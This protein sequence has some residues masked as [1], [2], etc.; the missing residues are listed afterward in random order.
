MNAVQLNTNI[1][2][3]QLDGNDLYFDP[4]TLYAPFGLLPW[5]EAGVKGLVLSRAGATWVAIPNPPAVD[6]RLEHKG[7]LQL[8]EDGTLSGHVTV[9]YSGLEALS[10]RI[11]ERHDDAA[12]R[13]RYLENELQADIPLGIN[14]E[15]VNKPDWDSSTAILIAE[16]H[17]SVQGWMAAA[18][19][20]R[21][22]PASLFGASGRQTFAHTTRVHPIYFSY[23]YRQDDDVTI[24][25]PASLVVDTVPQARSIDFGA[26]TYHTAAERT[27]AGLHQTRQLTVDG[28]L[29][30][31]K[32]YGQL[33]DF[34][35][36]V[37]NQDE[38][39]IVLRRASAATR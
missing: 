2:R 32:Y 33:H 16:F 26:L 3:V 37:R 18:G 13:R 7:Q 25:L 24:A 6:S 39:Q 8:S 1:V 27:D 23:P 15:L 4:G 28:T 12:G 9:T 5:A 19:S 38:Q 11:R 29:I 31:V 20:R 14:V 21:L 30:P 10:V 17:L 36:T 35:Q 34:F 22:L